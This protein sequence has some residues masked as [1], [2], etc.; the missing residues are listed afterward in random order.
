MAEVVVDVLNSGLGVSEAF[1]NP[2]G[3]SDLPEGI[4]AIEVA[5]SRVQNANLAYIFRIFGRSPRTQACDCERSMEPALPQTLFLMT[6]ANLQQKLA[7]S[8]VT[9]LVKSDRSDEAILEELFLATLTRFPSAQEKQSFT[10]YRGTK[11]DRQAAFTDALW[12]L[13]NTRE[14]ILNH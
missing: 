11:K 9:A 14:F 6:D 3:P 12:A 13:I 5:P 4:R 7:K 1:G 2:K 8:R 10:E